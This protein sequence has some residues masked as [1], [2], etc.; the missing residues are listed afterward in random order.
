MIDAGVYNAKDKV[1]LWKGQLV[2]K[3]TKG[4]PHNFTMAE[5]NTTL[6]RLTPTGWHVRP[7]QPI[8]LDDDSV[9]EPDLTI[10]RGANRDYSARNPRAQ[11]VALLIEVSDSSLTIDSREVLDAYARNGIPCYWIV[12]IPERRILVYTK[13]EGGCYTA[14]QSFSIDGIVPVILDGREVGQ[15][16]VRDILP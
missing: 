7:E 2:E 5:L 10:V 6:V 3:M 8:V 9:P 14:T 4:P 13:P 15:V 16:S 11:D 12:S 1:F